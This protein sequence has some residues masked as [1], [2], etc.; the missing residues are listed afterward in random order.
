MDKA[1]S[2][3]NELTGEILDFRS[4]FRS[5]I[6]ATVSSDGVPE[7]S[8]APYVS[9]EEHRL[10]IY[11]SGLARHTR[12]L[13][14][15][16]RAGLLF[17]E[18][19]QSAGNI[20]ARRLLSHSCIAESIPRDSSTWPQVLDRFTE[21]FG[22]FVDTLRALPD[23]QLFRLTPSAGSYVRGFAQAYRFEGSG[24]EKIRHVNPAVSRTAMP[25]WDGKARP[26][27]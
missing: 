26:R 11:V 13:L 4:K 22:K 6:L 9:D 12:N 24:M 19:E 10:Y 3:V 15:S 23:F 27:S 7:S 18:D 14:E 1:T 2:S 21:R 20:F 25:S 17:I 16:G 8:Y 5:V